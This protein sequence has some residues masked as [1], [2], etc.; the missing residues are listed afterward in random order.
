MSTRIPLPG[1]GIDTLMKGLDTGSNLM[2]NLMLNKYYNQ[3][4]PSG[5]VANAM[6]VEQ[7]RNQYGEDDPRYIQAKRA[8]DMVLAGRQSLIDTRDVLNQTAGVRYSSP[9]G[10]T[11]AEGKGRGAQDILDNNRR[12]RTAG[13]GRPPAGA[14]T[15]EGDQYY[16]AQGNPVYSDDDV[17]TN[18]RTPEEREAYE[19][20]IAKQTGDADA[21]NTLLRARNLDKTRKSINVE[22][23][24]R[25][26]GLKGMAHYLYE[27]AQ[28][29]A[30]N[31][32]D[33]FLANQQAVNSATLM[34]DQMRQFYKDSIQPSAMDRLRHLANPSTWYK[35][36]KVAQAQF[37]QLN[38]ILDQ[39]T[40]TYEN[41]GTSPIKLRKIKFE[42]GNFTLG[43]ATKEAKSAAAEQQ[44]PLDEGGGYPEEGADDQ[45]LAVY[46]PQLIKKNPKYTKENLKH[47]AKVNNMSVQDLINQLLSR[48]Q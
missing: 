19:R 26:S 36:P 5:D 13:A 48:G 37:N 35:D 8:H 15:R 38:K 3:L 11:I 44:L 7:L 25:Y 18:P 1:M 39:E 29:A 30:G 34:A 42:N 46:G 17:D 32:S 41:A 12:G 9:L 45:I 22:D 16:D 40:E 4:H 28:A 43:K 33:E 24:T 27:S 23:L 31:P 10:K 21:R 20:S 47:T 2:H 6:Y 14:V